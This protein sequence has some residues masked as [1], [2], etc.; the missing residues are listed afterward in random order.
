MVPTLLEKKEKESNYCESTVCDVNPKGNNVLVLGYNC[1][2][3]Y[4]N[5][6]I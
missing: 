6:G 3:S 4:Q 5:K 2:K 1:N